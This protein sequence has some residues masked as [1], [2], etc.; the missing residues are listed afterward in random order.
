M[1]SD[2]RHCTGAQK[3]RTDCSTGAH[4]TVRR[5]LASVAHAEYCIY[6]LSLQINIWGSTGKLYRF[7][8]QQYKESVDLSVNFVLLNLSLCFIALSHASSPK[9]RHFQGL[10]AKI[11]LSFYCKQSL[12]RNRLAY[13]GKPDYGPKF[14]RI[15]SS[16]VSVLSSTLFL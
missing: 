14:F 5:W 1:C 12:N 16:V 15:S 9:I 10:S 6:I 2:V 13:L 4:R 8:F 11:K 7:L 3:G